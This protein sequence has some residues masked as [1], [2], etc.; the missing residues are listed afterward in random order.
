MKIAIG[1]DHAGFPYKAPIIAALEH[2]GIEV[3][4][5]GTDLTAATD[6]PIYAFRVARA[7]A[8]KEADLGI[9]ICGTGVGMA[10]AAN[11][12]KG[13]RAGVAQTAF[14][15]KATREHN[16]A[17][18]LCLGSRTNTLAEVLAFVGIFLD[19]TFADGERH[20]QRIAMISDY[21]EGQ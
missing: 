10:I 7:V 13:I 14:A 2:R 8:G 18:I 9:L 5:Q 15:A 16:D 12:V 19:T 11:K 1:A 4:D 21:E 3:V 17:N 20:R 6:Y